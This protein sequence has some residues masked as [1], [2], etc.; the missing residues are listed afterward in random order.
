MVGR[1]LPR[2]PNFCKNKRSDVLA[3]PIL[4]PASLC[5]L[6]MNIRAKRQLC[7]TRIGGRGE[8]HPSFSPSGKII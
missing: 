5:S 6:A 8:L 4:P 2:R 7:P 1:A 3:L